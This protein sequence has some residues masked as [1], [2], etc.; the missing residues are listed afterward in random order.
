MSECGSDTR[1]RLI[2]DDRV[3]AFEFEFPKRAD[4]RPLALPDI[5]VHEEFASSSY[6]E[7]ARFERTPHGVDAL[8][9]AAV[10]VQRG[11]EGPGFREDGQI[12]FL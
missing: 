2:Q 1:L 5:V 11:S 7:D 10:P 4:Q 6:K 8:Q 3:T 9:D 12:L